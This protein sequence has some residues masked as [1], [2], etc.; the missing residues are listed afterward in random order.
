MRLYILIGAAG[1]ISAL[2][3]SR[4]LNKRD[5]DESPYGNSNSF[6]SE[7]GDENPS[8]P[9]V[10][11]G[12]GQA[13]NSSY[14]TVVQSGIGQAVTVGGD[15][16]LGF[17]PSSI[18]ASIGDVI[19]FVF[20]KKNHTLTQ[21][22]F[23]SPCTALPGGVDSGFRPNPDG[24]ANPAPTF[25]YTV[26]TMDPSWW[27]CKQGN[28][29][30]QGMVFAINPTVS[31]IDENKT[32]NAFQKKAMS[33]GDDT[34]N[35]LPDV[36]PQDT[37]HTG[38]LV[39][40]VHTV[41]VGGDAGLVYTP[42]SVN[43]ATGD[44]IRFIFEKQNHTVTQSTFASPCSPIEDGIDSGYRANPNNT[45]LPAPVFEYIVTDSDSKWW[46]CGQHDHCARG[47]VFAI[48]P[49][50]ERTIDMFIKAAMAI[51]GSSLS[52]EYPDSSGQRYTSENTDHGCKG[53]TS[54]PFGGILATTFKT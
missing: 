9:V 3:H 8:N 16:G 33:R 31:N 49:T 38:L 25:Q 35:T 37:S 43:A 23:G 48:N 40:T 24:T 26:E 34:E 17:S 50:P 20:Q 52:K 11:F 12:I 6:D 44:I 13:G 51:G 5:S 28:H 10:Q 18:H 15:A 47:M 42:S 27:F 45:I 1:M 21:S 7:Q 22:T 54:A 46:Y 2:P 30:Q 36:L 4:V 19:E 53:T 29:C 41:T 39:A 32:L 14:G